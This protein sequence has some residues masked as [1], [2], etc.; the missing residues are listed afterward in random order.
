MLRTFTSTTGHALQCNRCGAFGATYLSPAA[1]RLIA[2][3]NG[4]ELGVPCAPAWSIRA[5]IGDLCPKC[6]GTEPKEGAA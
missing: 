3:A 5:R 4:W 6:V 1:A 2:Q